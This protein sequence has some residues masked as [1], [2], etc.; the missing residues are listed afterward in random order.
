MTDRE[1]KVQMRQALD[2]SMPPLP[3][4]PDLTAKVLERY[5]E[6][7]R[8]WRGRAAGLRVAAALAV[9]VLV[10][11]SGLLI[12]DGS[13][14]RLDRWQS[15][16][17]QHY[18]VQGELVTPPMHSTAE[19]ADTHMEPVSIKTTDWNELV[20]ALGI[21][22]MAPSWLPDGWYLFHYW[23]NVNETL[24]MFNVTYQ[25]AMPTDD[26]PENMDY[27]VFTSTM[28]FDPN[29]PDLLLEQ[30]GAGTYV[31]LSN[32]ILIYLTVNY[33]KITALWIEGQTSYVLS[34]PLPEDDLLHI[35]RSMYGLD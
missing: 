17:E 11:C 31:Q 24:F 7:Q 20:D 16:D 10:V 33:E 34:A 22:P 9:M 3:D 1:L 25:K 14:I 30:D 6:K 27:L 5:E 4:D 29:G 23:A 12:R 13:Y 28:F 19:A 32:G 35:I 21:T 15:E 2:A 18:Y 26:D 8:V